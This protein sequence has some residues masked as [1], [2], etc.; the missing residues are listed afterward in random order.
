MLDLLASVDRVSHLTVL[1]TATPLEVTQGL[2]DPNA[3]CSDRLMD[4][5]SLEVSAA[6]PELAAPLIRF[7]Q[8]GVNLRALKRLLLTSSLTP[9]LLSVLQP[10]LAGGTL[11]ALAYIVHQHHGA[12]TLAQPLRLASLTLVAY[13]SVGDELSWAPLL[14]DLGHF[15]YDRLRTLELRTVVS[16]ALD[17]DSVAALALFVSQLGWARVAQVLATCPALEALTIRISWFEFMPPHPCARTAARVMRR[18][19]RAYLPLAVRESLKITVPVA[20]GCTAYSDL[21]RCPCARTKNGAGGYWRWQQHILQF[22]GGF[23]Y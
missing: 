6:S 13:V 23:K 10:L 9:Q 20:S 22:D 3:L 7:L 18:A 17:T 21:V 5:E 1:W 2:G 15:N 4:I 16:A 19:A 11:D 14:R 12:A 8:G